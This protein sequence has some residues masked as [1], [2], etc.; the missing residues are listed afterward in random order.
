MKGRIWIYSL[1]EIKKGEE[2]TYNYGFELDT[3][4][5]HP[6]RCGKSNCV[7]YIVDRKY[8]KRLGRIL[9]KRAEKEKKIAALEQRA[10]ELQKELDDELPVK[11]STARKTVKK[12]PAK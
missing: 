2:L 12:T 9:E 3:W 6:C 7:G 11:K 4:E 5:D 1:R 10:K 8:W